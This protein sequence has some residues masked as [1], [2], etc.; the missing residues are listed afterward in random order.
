MLS[1]NLITLIPAPQKEYDDCYDDKSQNPYA[2]PQISRQ[3][4]EQ[5]IKEVDHEGKGRIDEISKS[6]KYFLNDIP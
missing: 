6:G 1:M 5:G 4:A 2:R 3:E